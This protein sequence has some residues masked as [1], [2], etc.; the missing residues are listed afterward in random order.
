[1]VILS[2]SVKRNLCVP[3]AEFL[4]KEWEFNVGQAVTPFSLYSEPKTG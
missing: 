2:A 3:Y 1:M 4:K